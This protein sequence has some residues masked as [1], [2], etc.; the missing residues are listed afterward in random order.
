MDRLRTVSWSN[1]S[2]PTGVV[3]AV[4]K[5]PTHNKKD[6]QKQKSLIQSLSLYFMKIVTYCYKKIFL[7]CDRQLSEQLLV[8]TSQE[9]FDREMNV[10]YFLCI[11]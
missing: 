9:W 10:K 5:H 11:W 3:K 4:Y 8:H 1:K 6:T 7:L 2:H